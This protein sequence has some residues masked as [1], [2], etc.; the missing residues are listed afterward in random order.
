MGQALLDV[1]HKR[2][3]TVPRRLSALLRAMPPNTPPNDRMSRPVRW[4]IQQR[5]PASSCD[6]PLTRSS[7]HGAK[8]A[9]RRS[10][11]DAHA[12]SSGA[13]GPFR[14]GH[15]TRVVLGPTAAARVRMVCA[16]INSVLK[17]PSTGLGIRRYTNHTNPR[18]LHYSCPCNPQ[19]TTCNRARRIA[20]RQHSWAA[21][22]TGP[23]GMTLSIGKA[24]I[25]R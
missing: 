23:T 5:I 8:D 14:C 16:R 25:L 10:I 9:S 19:N 13:V 24:L 17:P 1:T 12:S 15:V 7:R 20:G 21:K 18:R 4:M 3:R 6:S 11:Y 2:H 22:A